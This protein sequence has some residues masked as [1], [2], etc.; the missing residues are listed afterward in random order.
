MRARQARPIIATPLPLELQGDD[1]C[2]LENEISRSAR[3]AAVAAEAEK[4]PGN[5][6]TDE[7]IKTHDPLGDED[8]DIPL[9]I[10]TLGWDP[11]GDPTR[12]G[13]GMGRDVTCALRILDL[14]RVG[15]WFTSHTHA[16][17]HQH[18]KVTE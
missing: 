6:N 11:A 13:Q 9:A 14:P 12:S 17:S 5:A 8:Y 7:G 18:P 16:D 10:M 2:A 1:T 4:F 15:V 3:E